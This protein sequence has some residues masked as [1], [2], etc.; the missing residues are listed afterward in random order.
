MDKMQFKKSKLTLFATLLVLSLNSTLL[1]GL[2]FGDGGLGKLRS[3]AKPTVSVSVLG[4]K[5]IFQKLPYYASYQEIKD[6][7]VHLD[8][9]IESKLDSLQLV[10]FQHATERTA[11]AIFGTRAIS[12]TNTENKYGANT[13]KDYKTARKYLESTDEISLTNLLKAHQLTTQSSPD[14]QPGILRNFGMLGNETI[15]LTKKQVDEINNNTYTRF[16]V[17]SRDNGLLQGL[18]EYPDAAMVKPGVY[19]ILENNNPDLVKKLKA[20]NRNSGDLFS[21]E[22]ASLTKELIKTLVTERIKRFNLSLKHLDKINK[23]DQ[24]DELIKLVAEFQ[25]D[26][27]SIHPFAD[28]NGRLSRLYCLYIPLIKHGIAP[29]WLKNP[30]DDITVSMEEWIGEIKNGI[31]AT[32]R[33]Y[34][35][36]GDRLHLNLAIENSPEWLAP[37]ITPLLIEELNNMSSEGKSEDFVPVLLSETDRTQPRD[38]LAFMDVLFSKD[39][40]SRNQFIKSPTVTFHKIIDAYKKF[41]QKN[42]AE[43]FNGIRRLHL[44]DRDAAELLHH[45]QSSI[46]DNYR[47]KLNSW[48]KTDELVWRGLATPLESGKVTEKEIIDIFRKPSDRLASNAAIAK[49]FKNPSSKNLV[50]AARDDFGRY[51]M[52]LVNNRISRIANSHV[53]VGPL[54]D[55]SY[56]FSTSKDEGLSK[57]FALGLLV[58]LDEGTYAELTSEEVQSKISARVL[59]GLRPAKYFID[60]ALL[61]DIKPKFKNNY[62]EER[63]VLGV[64]VADPDSVMIVKILNPDGTTKNTYIRNSITP[65]VIEVYDTDQSLQAGRR[66]KPI[67]AISL[68]DK[69]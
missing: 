37:L 62:P 43:N 58:F 17:H 25:R 24:R 22:G 41:R 53:S 18:I 52:D 10:D 49:S 33:L 9:R 35:D 38:L 67:K 56:F 28:G 65:S 11:K 64:G 29:P 7:V 13:F 31:T 50:N 36:L 32:E 2:S 68:F 57:Q 60:T 14:S 54:Y 1:G 8:T 12:R 61:E 19:K 6:D 27:V 51:N 15:G 69:P 4:C 21:E 45:P 3:N 55:E 47:A 42:Q 66:P 59:I 63:E 30:D 40:E 5:S 26:L 46:P 23:N 39:A 20:F 16:K 34:R 48:Y 44:V